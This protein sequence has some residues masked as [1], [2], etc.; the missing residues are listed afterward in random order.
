MSNIR[1]LFQAG[2]AHG[3]PFLAVVAASLW[4]APAMA[5]PLSFG[6]W[7]GSWNTTL[8]LGSSWRVQGPDHDL[9]HPADGALVGI[10]D[11]RGASI[12]DGGDLNY[13]SGDRFSTVAKFV[14]TLKLHKDSFGG[15]L[16]L[17]GWYDQAQ[18]K[19]GVRFGNQVNGY[20]QGNPLSDDGFE[21]LQKFRGIQLLDAYIYDT[22]YIDGNPLQLRLGRQVL[23]W[24]ESLFVPG[25]NRIN[26]FDIPALRRPGTEIK[27]ALLPAGMLYAN[28]GLKNGVSIEA[29]YQFE[30]Q[31][32]PINGCGSYWA[33]TETIISASPGGCP[34]GVAVGKNAPDSFANGIYVPLIH[35]REA[36]D[37][38]QGGFA[39]HF[40]VDAL[41]T[42]FG[43]YA[44]N[45][46]AR[47]PAVSAFTGAWNTPTGAP[48]P[49][50][51]LNPL[52]AHVNAG[53]A[54]EP[55]RAFWEYP[56]DIQIYGVS[57]STTIKGW[58][59]GS[60]LSY[61]P[62]TPAQRNAADLVTAGLKGAGP[63]GAEARGKAP[64]S[65]FRGYDRFHKTQFQLNAINLFP[66]VLG[67]QNFTVAAEA[68]ADFNNV[69]DNNGK[70]KRYGRAFIY[71]F[72]STPNIPAC[73]S[74]NPNPNGCQ[75][76]GY[77]TNFAFGYRVLGKLT[78]NSVFGSSFSLSP[79]LYLAHDVK[80]VSMDNLLNEGRMT[81][82]LGL[83]VQ[84]KIVNK[85]ELH[86]AYYA[87]S[88][89]YNP[90]R[91]RDFVS[92]SYSYTF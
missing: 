1:L 88:A 40:P 43:L 36:S 24:G 61:S 52:Q 55:I 68:I 80:G 62:N 15:V 54:S 13:K 76:D 45:I 64:N 83:G 21:N 38:G 60:E 34:M 66:R 84:Y 46:H 12:S 50:Q 82:G 35:G 42:Y 2:I 14:T 10:T 90:L 85:V 58:S 39:V 17:K 6:D 70:N 27:E 77:V 37:G 23:N 78:Y 7:D 79:S 22:Y 25:I 87:D 11:G 3:V 19:E 48:P 56:E 89:D 53:A 31:N 65:Y 74:S 67:A 33:V 29:F 81:V 92:L 69:P 57:A 20:Q 44:L 16:R 30:W 59:V 49:G 18:E 75:N 4:A 41:D 63:L 47:T 32:T 86:Y 51:P 71:G 5:V 91:D 28:L 9:I 73:G 8:S 72:G 26:A